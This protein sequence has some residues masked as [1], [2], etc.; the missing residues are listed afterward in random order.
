M[1]KDVIYVDLIVKWNK[2]YICFN[3]VCVIVWEKL[4]WIEVFEMWF[5]IGFVKVLNGDCLGRII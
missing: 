4:I 5:C 3:R 1:I 2:C